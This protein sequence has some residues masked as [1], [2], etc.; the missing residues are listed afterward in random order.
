M[1]SLQQGHDVFISCVSYLFL[2]RR[3]AYGSCWPLDDDHE[4]II[5]KNYLRLKDLLD[6]D[7]DL[8]NVMLSRDCLTP[9]RL[10]NIR[11]C[12]D[13]SERNKKLLE[14]LRRG[15]LEKFDS[16]VD[17]VACTQPH[18]VPLLSGNTGK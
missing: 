4:N 15:S 12:T 6:P 18:L 9:Q 10:I 16:F 17:C 13:V 7:D 5:N 3:S 14:Y 8:I 1:Y 2:V 11:N